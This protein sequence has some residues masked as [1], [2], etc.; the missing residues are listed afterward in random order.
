MELIKQTGFK[1]IIAPDG[2]FQMMV[3]PTWRYWVLENR[4]HCFED[5]ESDDDDC[6]QLSVTP[7]RA[8]ERVQWAEGLGY[9]PSTQAGD[10][11]CRGYKDSRSDGLVNL[12]TKKL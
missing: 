3:P 4:V 9:L 5:N 12:I 1:K 7:V 2:T 10:F 6:F 8:E 11:A